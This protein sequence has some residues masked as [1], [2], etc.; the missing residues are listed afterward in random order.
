MQSQRPPFTLFEIDINEQVIFF[1]S[2]IV[3]LSLLATAFGRNREIDNIVTLPYLIP[4][5]QSCAEDTESLEDIPNTL[6]NLAE[7]LR[8]HWKPLLSNQNS[9]LRLQA[10]SAASSNNMR[11]R[12]ELMTETLY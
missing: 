12:E 9:V 5:V 4:E 3:S 1:V 6:A 10:A 11:S 8:G 2:L 7:L